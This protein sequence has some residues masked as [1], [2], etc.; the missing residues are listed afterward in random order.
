MSDLYREAAAAAE[1]A[2]ERAERLQLKLDEQV[3]LNGQ[4]RRQLRES[5]SSAQQVASQ[6]RLLQGAPGSSDATCI[7]VAGLQRTVTVLR[8][9]VD[10]EKKA[11][12]AA[13]AE[14]ANLEKRL[15]SGATRDAATPTTY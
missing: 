6:L 7:S 5:S 12:N 9:R 8:D 11:A 1:R 4:L 3:A 2:E 10:V 15:S 13:Q 14:C